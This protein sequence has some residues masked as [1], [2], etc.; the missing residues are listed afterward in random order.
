MMFGIGAKFRCTGTKMLALWLVLAFGLVAVPA[1]AGGLAEGIAAYKRGDYGTARAEW[2]QAAEA[3]NLDALFNLGQLYR[4]GKGVARDLDRAVDYYRRAAEAGHVAA[5]GNLGTLYYFTLPGAPHVADAF[6]WWEKAAAEGDARSQYLLG[7]LY[8]NGSHVARNYAR[9]YGWTLLAARAGLEE[10]IAAEKTMFDLLSPEEIED[11]KALAE[12]LRDEARA[13][14]GAPEHRLP[15]EED[16]DMEPAIKATEPAAPR[17]DVPEPV[18]PIGAGVEPDGQAPDV[19]M[20]SEGDD[21]AQGIAPDA[22]EPWAGF[23]VQL[24]AMQDPA[25][26]ERMVVQLRREHGDLLDEGKLRL[27][28]PRTEARFYRLLLGPFGSSDQ[29]GIR[30]ADLQARGLECFVTAERD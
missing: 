27:R 4:L 12:T 5:Q 13:H 29:A 10:A 15:P 30:C 16:A 28:V 21:A 11:G 22:A 8:F 24:M 14:A 2:E 1:A 3:G 19:P 9:A 26:A 20:A 23:Y 25:V 6:T 17:E 18:P 7:V